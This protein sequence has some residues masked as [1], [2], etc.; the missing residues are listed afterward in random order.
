MNRFLYKT[1]SVCPI[2][3]K[4][5]YA[6]INAYEDGI[7]MDKACPEHGAVS[8]LIWAD[9]EENYLNWLSNGGLD[10]NALPRSEEE[11]DRATAGKDFAC[12]ACQLPASSALMTTNRCNMNCPVC[13]TRDQK[14]LLHEPTLQECEKLIRAYREKAGKDA[15]LEFCGGEPTVREDICDLAELARDIGFDYIQLNT[16]GIKLAESEEFCRKL[17]VS[18]VT[19]VYMGFDGMTDKPYYAK[20]GRSLLSVKKQ[21]VKNCAAA[22]LAVVLV[23]CVIPGENDAELGEILCFAVENMPTVK[24]LYLQP[25]SYFGIYPEDNIRRITIPDVIRKLAEQHADVKVTDF[26]PGAYDH[27]QCSFNACYLLDQNG[28]LKPLTRFS[29]RTV[30]A[31]AVHRLRTNLRMTWLPSERNMLTIGGMAFQD[32]W[33]ID[34]MRVQKCS[35]QIMQK[36]GKLIPLCSKYLSGCNGSKIFP[37]IG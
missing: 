20:Y 18:G 24:G 16:N 19:T 17:K 37:G 29:P 34:L 28:K 5:V 21:A 1:K 36:D 30:E 2:C 25:I 15:L 6:D 27:A 10:V 3:L 11:V 7:H 4:E 12:E 22:G 35:I 32:G 13:F 14:E 31:D 8:T 26:G 23:T 33:N 9:T